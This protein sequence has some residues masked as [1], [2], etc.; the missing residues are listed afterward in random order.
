MA[1][2]VETWMAE[3]LELGI[4]DTV[5]THPTGGSLPGHQ[6]SLSTF[7]LSGAAGEGPA[8]LWEPG[9]IASGSQAT[10]T[11]QAPGAVIG[12]KV[13]ASL[14]TIGAVPLF[15]SAH[16]SDDNEVTVVLAN[17]TGVS[18]TIA[19]GTLSVLVFRHRTATP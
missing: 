8:A 14:T 18:Q 3:D 16:V 12:D 9:V 2:I 19:E 4:E 6:I 15:F 11:I 7:S 5:K 13:L 10:T 17:F 1:V